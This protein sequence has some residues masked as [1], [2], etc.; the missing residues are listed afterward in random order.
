MKARNKV[1]VILLMLIILIAS[2]F[3][4]NYCYADDLG[5][6]SLNNYKG[7]A[8]TPEKLSNRVGKILGIIRIIGT[9]TSVV[10]LIVIGLKFM[11]GSVEEKAEYKQ[12][13]KPYIIGA[14]LLFTGT[15]I[16]QVIYKFSKEI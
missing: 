14:L 5:L 3:I 7:G 9:V 15:I 6:G 12:S 4:T 13:L 8:A 16:P 10:M 2:F 11:L 1:V